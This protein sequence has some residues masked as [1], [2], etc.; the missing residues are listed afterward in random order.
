MSSIEPDLRAASRV[1]EARLWQRHMA[2]AAIGATPKGGVNRQ[3]LHQQ[4]GSLADRIAAM[5]GQFFQKLLVA[6]E[7]VGRPGRL[8]D[9]N[10]V[11]LFRRHE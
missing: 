6:E 2:M 1:S 3:A 4:A 10:Q 8:E 7:C 11:D 9:V 5:L